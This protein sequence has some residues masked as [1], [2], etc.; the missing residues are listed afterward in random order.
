MSSPVH[1]PPREAE[2]VVLRDRA[3]DNLTFI[4]DTMARSA[5]LTAISGWGAVAEGFIA[6]A[7][8]FAGC[9][10]SAADWW[11]GVWIVVACLGCL[12]GFGTMAFKARRMRIPVFGVALKKFAMSL[13]PPIV[14]GMV[15]TEVFYERQ[16]WELI[17]G[18]WLMLYGV[19][20]VTGGAFSVKVIPLFGV[21]FM[22]LALGAFYPAVPLT[23]VLFWKFR[24]CD[25][26]LAAG[27][28]LFHILFGMIIA[29]RYNG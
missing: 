23:T 8:A 29:L 3:L 7:G 26:F 24:L 16:L 10:Y 11:I 28:G 17:P 13:F 20:V 25:A 6:L 21:C 15:L 5:P 12:T 22:L 18:T 9:L 27:F 1:K 4:R 14:A 19:G 2:T